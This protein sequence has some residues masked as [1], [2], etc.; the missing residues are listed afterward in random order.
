MKS[1]KI[2]I[3]I[4]TLAV[5]SAAHAAVTTNLQGYYKLDETSGTAVANGGSLAENGQIVSG[6]TPGA[7]GMIGTSYTLD[8]G[9]AAANDAGLTAKAELTP[10]ASTL[11]DNLVIRR[12][13]ADADVGDT[14][15]ATRATI[16]AWIRPTS[17]KAPTT[18][19]NGRSTILATNADFQ[20]T[21]QN[22][23]GASNGSSATAA[24]LFFNY[25]VG[26]AN[27]GATTLTSA[28]KVAV[29]ATAPWTHV[30]VTR[31]GG[32]V[33]FYV[34]GVA[35]ATTTGLSASAFEQRAH[36]NLSGS[37]G[38]ADKYTLSL[39][40][41]QGTAT[42]DFAGGIDDVGI[43]VGESLTPQQVAA[44]A[45]LGR[46]SAAGLDDAGIDA[47]LAT[48]AAGS[49]SATVG[50]D[51]WAYTTDF[52]A[53]ADASALL[54]GKHY[55]DAAG[56]EYIILGGTAGNF[57][58]VAHLVPEPASLAALAGASLVVLRRRRR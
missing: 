1:G 46:F 47:V 52:A 36:N 48:Y 5:A 4:A 7:A 41:Q 8:D 31:D 14:A 35:V 20:F 3:G 40:T 17:N 54:A 21:L 49:G 24:D 57:T 13:S 29:G 25:R 18:G 12:S 56:N 11:V 2:L 42:R 51:T 27:Q 23:A 26:G 44:V 22:S 32:T 15:G 6:V 19:A 33:T 39:G 34:N 10:G 50:G 55:A 16:G 38:T 37:G 58:G 43:W 45:G 53:P 30:A 9:L 28:T